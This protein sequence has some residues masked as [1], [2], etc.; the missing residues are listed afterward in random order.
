LDFGEISQLEEVPTPN[1]S[2]IS[3]V[4]NFLNIPE[5]QTLKN[6]VYTSV[7]GEEEQ[8]VLVVL[9]GDDE[10]N[11]VKLKNFLG[12]N[13]LAA[14]TDEAIETLGLVKGFIGPNDVKDL[15]TLV[16]SEVD[17][18]KSYVVG[19][20]KVDFHLKGYV[21]QRDGKN[22]EQVDLRL[23]RN[24]DSCCEC[25]KDVVEKKGI[26]VGHIFQLGDKYTKSM[27]ATVLNVNGK[28]IAPVMGCYGIGVTRL[29]ASAIEQN[30]DENG[31]I[32]PKEI[33]P[34]HIYL[35]MMA[36]K[37]ENKE[38]GEKI[39]CDLKKAGFE[40]LFDDRGLGFGA[41]MKDAELLGLPLAVVFGERDFV[42]TG[43]VEIRV[44]KNG[45]RCKVAL[46]SLVDH[47]VK[48]W[49]EI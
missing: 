37:D 6:L 1:K 48:T 23:S 35:A 18:E 21:F 16:D 19:A 4:A 12:S 2:T 13:H 47:V 49:K 31:I 28:A 8:H 26:E 42:K 45:E 40:V 17:V 30:H 22:F 24:G 41:M 43:E 44:R 27:N 36:K 5:H 11:E 39:Y 34:F 32:W 25:G 10:V 46:D 20:G 33:A 7:T 9:L 14:A 15:K 29:A 38:I 3:D